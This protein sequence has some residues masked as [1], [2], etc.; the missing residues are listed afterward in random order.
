M[1]KITEQEL[2]DF[3]LKETGINISSI[4]SEVYNSCER[5]EYEIGINSN[6]SLILCDSEIETSRTPAGLLLN[7]IEWLENELD[8][9]EEVYEGEHEDIKKSIDK[10]NNIINIIKNSKEDIEIRPWGF[11]YVIKNFDKGELFEESKALTKRIIVNPNRRLSLQSHNHR[12]EIWHIVSGSGTVIIGEKEY[13]TKE[14]S[15]YFIEQGVKHRLTAGDSILVIEE[16]QFGEE[17]K[18]D[19]IIRYEDDYGRKS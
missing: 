15:F 19:D 6:N 7:V 17:L 13:L 11:Y 16:I 1:N 5:N 3:F 9:N 10:I 2:V 18:E 8:Y 12:N 4:S 14:G